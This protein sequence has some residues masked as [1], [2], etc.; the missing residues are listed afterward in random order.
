MATLPSRS[1]KRHALQMTVGLLVLV[2]AQSFQPITSLYRPHS[3]PT[4]VGPVSYS[5]GSD[6]SSDATS[7]VKDLLK[8]KKAMDQDEP[9]KVSGQTTS[10]PNVFRATN[11]E[12]CM[13]IV[14]NKL[15]K[16]TVFF[17]HASWCRACKRVEPRFERLAHQNPGINVIN[18]KLTPQSKHFIEN[19]LSIPSIPYGAIFH[20]Q[21]GLV[22]KMSANPKHFDV[23][24]HIVSSYIAGGSE[25][26]QQNDQGVFVAPYS[27]PI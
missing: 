17:F 14:E 10:L 21:A 26:S 13:D 3:R 19:D 6:L 22:E 8:K 24:E 2:F 25:L 4:S 11:K 1:R 12:E 23:F 15:D 18:V 16:L 7:L 27:R 5:I 20:P 9:P